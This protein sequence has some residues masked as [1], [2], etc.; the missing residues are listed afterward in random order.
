M[1]S[2]EVIITIFL[3]L[4]WLITYAFNYNPRC[5]PGDLSGKLGNVTVDGTTKAAKGTTVDLNLPFGD[6]GVVGNM[7][8]IVEGKILLACAIIYE[9]KTRKGNQF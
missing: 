1:N 6:D 3:F 2:N 8:Q 9:Y 5:A 7:L 4:H